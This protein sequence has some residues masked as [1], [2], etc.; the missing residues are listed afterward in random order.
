M[1][2]VP[3]RQHRNQPS[4]ASPAPA[5][6]RV[7]SVLCGGNCRPEGVLPSSALR[8]NPLYS[9]IHYGATW[10]CHPRRPRPSL[11][12]PHPPDRRKAPLG[13]TSPDATTRSP[14]SAHMSPAHT[15]SSAAS[16]RPRRVEGKPSRV[17][18]RARVVQ[19]GRGEGTGERAGGAGC[20]GDAGGDQGPPQAVRS[21]G[22]SPWVMH[23]CC[24][25][26]APRRS[27][28]FPTQ[29]HPSTAW[30]LVVRPPGRGPSAEGRVVRGGAPQYHIP[31]PTLPR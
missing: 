17:L 27:A 2:A 14:I 29:L 31:G 21:Q 9:T 30:V 6:G 4:L 20:V 23:A 22:L 25:P 7:D 26:P 16:T 28:T 12:N 3:A 1:Y 15:Y 19:L 24:K 10:S 11:P 18:S 8:T 5:P 13:S